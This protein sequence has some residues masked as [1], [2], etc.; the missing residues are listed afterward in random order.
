MSHSPIGGMFLTVLSGW[1]GDTF[2]S[3]SGILFW[4]EGY[5]QF[6]LG[7]SPFFIPFIDERGNSF[8]LGEGILF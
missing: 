8:F 7:E 1:G 3:L 4:G 6:F 5:L 2:L